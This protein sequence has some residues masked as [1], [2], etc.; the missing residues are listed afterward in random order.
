[1]IQRLS[2]A[3]LVLLLG[4]SLGGCGY[5]Q[6]GTLESDRLFLPLLGQ[7]PAYL[8]LDLAGQPGPGGLIVS[9]LNFAGQRVA[10]RVISLPSSS[11]CWGWDMGRGA[12]VE[13][14]AFYSLRLETYGPGRR[15]IPFTFFPLGGLSH[16][17]RGPHGV[18]QI[19]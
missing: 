3:L 5:R 8:R 14:L 19:K 13:G 2:R 10:L 6:Q 18:D 1:M 4:L 16:G 12:R 9:F 7:A 11:P 17:P 15:A